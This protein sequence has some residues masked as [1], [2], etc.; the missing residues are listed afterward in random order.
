MRLYA[1][2]SKFAFIKTA[3]TI[4][5]F[6]AIIGVF[7][8]GVNTTAQRADSENYK[9]TK[10]NINRAI[11][12]CYAVEG[13]YP[14]DIQYLEKNYGLQIDHSKYAVDLQVIGENVMPINNLVRLNNK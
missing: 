9:N 5:I 8:Y 13:K 4:V 1:S 2:R 3:V 10:A 12:A 7:I 11:V 6:A 14:Q